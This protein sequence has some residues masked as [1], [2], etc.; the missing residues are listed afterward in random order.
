ME[1]VFV[2]IT[3]SGEKINMF[4]SPG[5]VTTEIL[6]TWIKDFIDFLRHGKL[7]GNST[8]KRRAKQGAHKFKVKDGVLFCIYHPKTGIRRERKLV[9]AIPFSYIPE[10]LKLSHDGV[11]A[12]L[13]PANSL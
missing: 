12:A 13:L 10:I 1:G 6:E 8:R 11:T 5:L 7:P 9:P 4:A 3:A 2:I